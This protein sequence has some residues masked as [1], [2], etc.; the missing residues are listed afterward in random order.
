MVGLNLDIKVVRFEIKAKLS[1]I[2]E[3]ILLT[4]LFV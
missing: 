2:N 3:K 4:F 1:Y